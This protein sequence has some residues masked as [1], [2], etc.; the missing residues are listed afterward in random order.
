MLDSVV[1]PDLWRHHA[2]SQ[3]QLPNPPQICLHRLRPKNLPHR[4]SHTNGAI[5]DTHGPLHAN[6]I[7]FFMIVSRLQR[8]EAIARTKIYQPQWPITATCSE[9]LRKARLDSLPAA[10][11]VMPWSISGASEIYKL[12]LWQN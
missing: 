6:D 9:D 12:A 11:E 5:A 2:I 8:K 1:I 4:A 3:T 10:S 7:G